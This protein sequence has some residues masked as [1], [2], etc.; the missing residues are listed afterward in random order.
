MR[1]FPLLPALALLLVGLS[2]PATASAQSNTTKLNRSDF[3]TTGSKTL[4]T[5]GLVVGDEIHLTLD[6]ELNKAKGE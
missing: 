4:E 6:V 5:G 2:A 1:M 3:G